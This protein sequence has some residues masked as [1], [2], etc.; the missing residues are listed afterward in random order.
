MTAP[1]RP[2]FR[3]GWRVSGNDKWGREVVIFDPRENETSRIWVLPADEV[4]FSWGNEAEAREAA[5][6]ALRDLAD[7]IERGEE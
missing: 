4:T 3:I 6:A 5:A 1:K 2:A 7:R